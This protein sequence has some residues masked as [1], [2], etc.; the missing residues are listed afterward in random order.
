MML[1]LQQL[2][3]FFTPWQSVYGNSRMLSTT[4]AVV[5]VASL[6]FGGGY[7]IAADRLTLRAWRAGNVERTRQLT[8]L[9]A[10]HRPVLI[11]LSF[12]FLSGA[13][14]AAADVKTFASSPAFWI[15]LGFVALLVVNGAVLNATES[16]LRRTDGASDR[17]THVRDAEPLWTRLRAF[18]LCSVA[19]WTATVIAGV[20]LQN[21]S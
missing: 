1:S 19:L 18:A 9:R 20:V 21:A 5:H 7:A 3:H 10:V 15:K 6:L 11:A 2:E 4:I 16:G 12:S 13:L 8:E 14:L 17:S